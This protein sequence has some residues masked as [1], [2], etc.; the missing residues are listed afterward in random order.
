M[1]WG[2]SLAD[3][4]EIANNS[5]I[6]SVIPEEKKALGY[7]KFRTEWD[8]FIDLMFKRACSVEANIKEIVLSDM[9]PNFDNFKDFK[10]NVLI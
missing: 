10:I 9:Q 3:L 2:L 5:L 1:G 8:F 4:K 6:Y 7:A